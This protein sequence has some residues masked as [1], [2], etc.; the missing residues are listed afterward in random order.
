M[1]WSI[2]VPFKGYRD[3]IS[4]KLTSL[5]ILKAEKKARGAFRKQRPPRKFC[6]CPSTGNDFRTA[7]PFGSPFSLEMLVM[8]QGKK[9]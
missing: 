5:A 4:A 3:S 1:C 6:V 9:Y 8:I 2:E 7:S